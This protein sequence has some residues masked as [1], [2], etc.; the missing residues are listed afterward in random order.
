MIIA[1][2]CKYVQIGV[3]CVKCNKW[4]HYKC[5]VTNET[6]IEKLGKKEFKCPSCVTIEIKNPGRCCGIEEAN[7]SRS[8]DDKGS[9]DEMCDVE[10]LDRDVG[11]NDDLKARHDKLSIIV[12]EQND[13][14]A[15]LKNE[16]KVLIRENSEVKSKI[17]KFEDQMSKMNGENEKMESKMKTAVEHK[18]E[19]ASL[20]QKIETLEKHIVTLRATIDSLEGVRESNMIE[21]SNL[22]IERDTHK[23]IGED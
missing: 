20:Y 3:L 22:K 21:I 14:I 15:R 4:Y 8:S 11:D 7:S 23:E 12:E 10:N 2:C 19:N 18:H 9:D 17:K 5:A 6:T 1:K 13:E 16:S